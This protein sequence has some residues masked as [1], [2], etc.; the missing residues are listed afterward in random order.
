[1]LTLHK[2]ILLRQGRR[3][4]REG[5]ERLVNHHLLRNCLATKPQLSNDAMEFGVER[6]DVGEV[7]DSK[8]HPLILCLQ[9]KDGLLMMIT[10]RQQLP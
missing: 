6:E 10:R 4:W 5:S 7:Y 2:P 1:M 9:Q 3:S 8:M